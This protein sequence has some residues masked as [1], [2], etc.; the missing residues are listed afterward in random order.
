[1]VMAQK[2]NKRHPEGQMNF[3]HQKRSPIKIQ[4]PPAYGN[5]TFQDMHQAKNGP[6]VTANIQT[7]SLLQA[8][9]EALQA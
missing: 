3:G 1:M 8:Q 5:S 9:V 7:L 4:R 6:E 2:L